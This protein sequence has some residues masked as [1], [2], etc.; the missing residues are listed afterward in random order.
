MLGLRCCTGLSLAA[1]IRDHSPVM[2]PPC[3]LAGA[4]PAVEPRLWVYGLQQLRLV[5]P[6]AKAQQWWGTGLVALQTVD[7]TM[8]L[9]LANRFCTTEPPRK[10]TYIYS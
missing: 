6:K 9:A 8:A 1:V 3:L 10:P 4:S 5:G 2:L 7:Q